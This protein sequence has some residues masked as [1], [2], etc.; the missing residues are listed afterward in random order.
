MRGRDG[1]RE[2]GIGFGSEGESHLRQ[3]RL[4][5][6]AALRIPGI[7]NTVILCAPLSKV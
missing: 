7:S 2:G 3:S 5:L 1:D 4:V 6:H